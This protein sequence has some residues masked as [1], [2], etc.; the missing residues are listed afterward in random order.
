MNHGFTHYQIKMNKY[1]TKYKSAKKEIKALKLEI[2]KF[3]KK[4]KPLQSSNTRR[5]KLNDLRRMLSNFDATPEEIHRCDQLF[6]K[7]MQC[8]ELMGKRASSITTTVMY[9]GL[10]NVSKI[11]LCEHCPTTVATVN[12]LLKIFRKNNIEV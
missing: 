6:L 5:I 1:K 9:I 2:E 7:A 11:Q 3:K 10:S 8:P 12:N 4:P